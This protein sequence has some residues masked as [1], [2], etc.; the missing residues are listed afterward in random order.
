MILFYNI[1]DTNFFGVELL[2]AILC[3]N[4]YFK[5][6]LRISLKEYTVVL[7]DIGEKEPNEWERRSIFTEEEL[8]KME[9]EENKAILGDVEMYSFTEERFVDFS[10][11]I[12]IQHGNESSLLKRG[13]YFNISPSH[14]KPCF[15]IR[16]S[17]FQSADGKNAKY[18]DDGGIL[19]TDFRLFLDIFNATNI[20]IRIDERNSGKKKEETEKDKFLAHVFAREEYLIE[21]EHSSENSTSKITNLIRDVIKKDDTIKIR[22]TVVDGLNLMIGIIKEIYASDFGP[23]FN[24]N[25][26]PHRKP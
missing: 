22:S 20:K 11:Y 3:M 5:D 24:Q 10:V 4:F 23:I 1:I 8:A 21:V 12:L 15:F 17:Q 26:D 9:L 16:S 25:Y 2:M 13:I 18:N 19:L 6:V 7:E 14:Y